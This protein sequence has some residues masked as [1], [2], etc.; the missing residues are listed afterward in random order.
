MKLSIQN[1]DLELHPSGAIFWENKKALLIA[2][3]HLGKIGHFRKNGLAIPKDAMY[4]NFRRL[5]VV[6][7]LYKPEII[8]FLGDLFHSD[9]N[10]EFLLFVDWIKN[11]KA[12]MVLIEG[13]HD[14]IDKKNYTDLGIIVLEDLLET[15]FYFTHHPTIK[16]NTINFCGHIHPGI[17]LKGKGKQFVKLSCFYV[18]ENQII[19]PSFGTFTGNYYVSPT[20]NEQIYA[21]VDKEVVKIVLKTIFN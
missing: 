7:D 12:K 1:Q 3:I 13:N 15:P 20:K 18:K 16:E 21:I 6:V 8:Y 9:Y 5:D 4:E 14:I 11:Q 19:L 2:D 10:L 17:K